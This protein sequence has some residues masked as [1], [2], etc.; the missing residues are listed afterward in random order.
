MTLQEI[1]KA[2][3]QGLTVHWSTKTYIVTQDQLGQWYIECTLNNH[4]IGLTYVDGVTLTQKQEEFFIAEESEQ[5]KST[6]S[7]DLISEINNWNFNLKIGEDHYYGTIDTSIF[8]REEVQF[9]E[10]EDDLYEE[11][12]TLVVEAFYNKDTN[13]GEVAK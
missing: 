5:Q 13:S 7:F 3:D 11:L 2:V 6:C 1:K 9:D 10:V 4:N 12:Q 8:G